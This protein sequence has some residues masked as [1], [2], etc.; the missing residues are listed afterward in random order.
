MIRVIK[1]KNP[2]NYYKELEKLVGK[3]VVANVQSSKENFYF[4]V[5]GTLKNNGHLFNV[6]NDLGKE[7]AQI[8]F[9]HKIVN[10]IKNNQIKVQIGPTDE[11]L[12]EIKTF[13]QGRMHILPS[14]AINQ[15]VI[16]T[17]ASKFRWP[18]IQGKLKYNKTGD[19][20]YI[21]DYNHLIQV[22]FTE[23]M[24][25]NVKRNKLILFE[26]IGENVNNLWR[27]LNSHD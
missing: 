8:Y 20:Y 15:I 5:E 16:V 1:K 4:A 3:T 13:G 22:R 17:L 11:I 6:T 21:Q 25:F 27:K 18:F 24:I 10:N 26:I 9:H 7:S 23:E 19:F 2:T 12:E 14:D